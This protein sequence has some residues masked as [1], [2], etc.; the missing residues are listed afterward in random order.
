MGCLVWRGHPGQITGSAAHNQDSSSL[1]EAL[2]LRRPRLTAASIARQ[3]HQTAR[4]QGW[5]APAYSTVA[6]II[7]AIDPA[8]MT[9]AQD[10]LG[11]AA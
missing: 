6:G 1:I 5:P 4:E 10:G 9:L 11:R 8:L 7:A 2:A 3:V